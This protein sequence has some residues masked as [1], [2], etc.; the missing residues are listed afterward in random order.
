MQCIMGSP[1]GYRLSGLWIL[2][3]WEIWPLS[4]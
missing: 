1:S 4:A 2:D 3:L